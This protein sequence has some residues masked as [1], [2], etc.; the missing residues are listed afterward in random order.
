MQ[1]YQLPLGLCNALVKNFVLAWKHGDSH[2]S[3]E[4]L[5]PPPPPPLLVT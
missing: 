1:T 4:K 2:F 5:Y 3:K